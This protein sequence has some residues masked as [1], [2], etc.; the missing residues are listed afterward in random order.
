MKKIATAIT[1]AV[2]V[3]GITGVGAS[4]LS[5]TGS[6][7]AAG[8]AKTEA[9]CVEGSLV[10]TNPVVTGQ[11]NGNKVHQVTIETSPGGSMAACNGQTML[12]EVAIDGT[13]KRAYGVYK[14]TTSDV[15]SLTFGFVGVTD[16]DA[17]VHD[18]VPTVDDGDL[19]EAGDPVDPVKAKEFGQTDITI[20]KTWGSSS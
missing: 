20:A 10:V 17:T 4:L 5:L 13:P 7:T 3:F 11:E 9:A 6:D 2:M 16:P 1:S 15:T 19:V 18:T 14:F 8:S 12:V